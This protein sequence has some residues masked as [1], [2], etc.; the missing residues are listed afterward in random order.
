LLLLRA[1]SGPS[2][3]LFRSLRAGDPSLYIVGCHDDQFVLKKSF[4]DR[5][6]LVP[7]SPPRA[8]LRALRQII[9][10]ERIDLVI[11]TT[12]EDVL[13]VARQREKLPCRVFLPR[14]GIIERCQDKY[15]LAAFLR[16]RRIAVPLT[17]AIS[18]LARIEGLFRRFDRPLLWCRVRKGSGSFAAIPVKRPDQ[19]RSWIQYWQ[20]MRRI[21]PG[22]FTLSEYLPGRDFCV[23][24]LWRNGHLVL[25]KM[26]ERI[27][28]IDTGSPSGVSS[29]A[30]LAKTAFEPAA[31]RTCAKAIRALDP[32]ASGAFFVDMKENEQG[33]ACIT[34]INA[35]RFAS[36]TNLHDLAGLHNMASLYVRL[37]MGD[38]VKLPK[39]YDHAEDYY[40]IRS[41]DTIPLVVQ[42]DQLFEG[43]DD[44]PE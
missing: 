8:R 28:Y 37:G 10:T 2:A 6:Y 20:E 24:G 16:R 14:T 33:V 15:E 42:A 29:M 44:P 1:G 38:R 39:P 23:Q 19:A 7:P 12:D 4:A 17:Y 11:P 30:S 13:A 36:M 22:S 9:K 43:I 21:P 18:S 3:S 32:K 25:A 41:V 5:N 34:E 35:G 27:A 40:V 31:M 26:A